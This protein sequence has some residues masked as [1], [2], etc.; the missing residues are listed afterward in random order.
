MRKINI[1]ILICTFLLTQFKVFSISHQEILSALR[2]E[3]KRSMDSLFIETLQKPYYIEYNLKITDTYRAASLLGS[4]VDSSR[5]KIA[6]LTVNVRVGDYEFDN[7]NFLD[8]SFLFFM[9][10]GD[11]GFG[12][13]RSIPINFDYF[14]LRR[15]LWLATDF[16]Y[17]NAL[18]TYTKKL[19]VLKN[20]VRRDS[21][22]DF[23]RAKP[24]SYIDTNF[25]LPS[26]DFISYC[27]TIK[28]I[29]S[30]FKD[31]PEINNSLVTF[32]YIQDLVYYVNSE[33]IEYVK[34][35]NFSGF[36][37]AGA[38]QATDG[39]PIYNFYSA[40]S[41][42]PSR[43]PSN[44]SLR[45]GVKSL[46]ENLRKILSSNPLEDSYS[47]PI[48]FVGQAAAELFA[49]VFA[50]NLVAQRELLSEQGLQNLSRYTSFQ[51]KIG[52]RVLP[53]FIS[54]V[55]TPLKKEYN[56]IPLLGY[57]KV[58]DEGI[59]AQNITLVENGYLKTLLTD[60]TPVN[61]ILYSNGNNREGSAMFSNLEVTVSKK[62]TLPEKKLKEKLIQLC[63]QRDLPYGI[64]VKKVVNQ[65]ILATVLYNLAS[66]D[67]K[68]SGES[69]LIRV[70]EAYK[71]YSD[72]REEVI[73][74][75][76]LKGFTVQSFKDIIFTGEKPFVLNYLA[77]IVS[78]SLSGGGYLGASIIIPSLLFEDG[79]FKPLESDFQKPPFLKNPISNSD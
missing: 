43:L 57:F 58:D 69:S 51:S 49:Q 30:L 25:L 62:Y 59:L 66:L 46:C 41:D 1:F 17:K 54:V 22:P 63:K 76:E 5:A 34:S 39:M 72:G 4:L 71:V 20:R 68:F 44:D 48:L 60:R 61:R 78:S 52:G 53:E 33:G 73:R 32:E 2:D 16:A 9:G 77:P 50:P 29:S 45:K 7:S 8:F 11:Q 74:G 14:T 6:T 65:N 24:Y 12:S 37:S 26:I 28:D 70:I 10:D 67:Y 19:S 36:E 47:G 31:Y 42:I 75:G 27:Q 64:I 15:E 79:E 18:E 55:S 13:R 21:L 38:T 23:A 40:Y 3:L 35:R 56:G